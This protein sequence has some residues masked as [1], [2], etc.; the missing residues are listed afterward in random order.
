MVLFG[1]N[2]RFDQ[3]LSM[4]ARDGTV[5]VTLESAGGGR[6][7]DYDHAFEAVLRRARGDGWSLDAVY[8]VSRSVQD[9]PAAERLIHP[10]GEIDFDDARS[11]RRAIQRSVALAHREE[12]ASGSGNPQKRIEL[13][14][15]HPSNHATGFELA[16]APEPTAAPAPPSYQVDVAIRVKDG[17]LRAPSGKA[18]EQS[19]RM[20]NQTQMLLVNRITRNSATEPIHVDANVDVA[21]KTKGV[22]GITIAEVKSLSGSNEDSQLRMAI[23]EVL[24]FAELEHASH[25]KVS[26]VIFVPRQPQKR[27]YIQVCE[28]ADIQLTWP[29][30]WPTYL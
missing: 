26:T 3:Q 29:G 30:N 8:L 21:W 12:G 19:W 20:H 24:Y 17:K 15:S 18:L 4:D 6:N 22:P 16:V 23:G 5:V 27:E 1:P 13:V 25:E 2:G 14:F 7:A 9:L 28:R 10:D 11:A